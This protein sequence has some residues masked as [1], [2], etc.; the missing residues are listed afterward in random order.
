MSSDE[1]ELAYS[2]YE[3]DIYPTNF[4]KSTNEIH[5]YVIRK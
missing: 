4:I 2:M 1:V 3:S 5:L